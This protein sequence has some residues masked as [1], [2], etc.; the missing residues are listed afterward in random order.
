MT[1]QS[2]ANRREAELREAEATLAAFDVGSLLTDDG[3]IDEVAQAKLDQL[4]AR[5]EAARNLLPR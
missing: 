5:V 2:D 3:T 4:K 1:L